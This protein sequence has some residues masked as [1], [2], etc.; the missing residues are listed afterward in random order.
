[1]RETLY[2]RQ[3]AYE[4]LRAGRRQLFRLTLVDTLRGAD[5]IDDILGLAKAAGVPVERVPRRGLDW[6]GGAR[7]QGVMLETSEYP[8]VGVDEILAEAHRRDEVPFL[9]LLDLVKDPQNLGSLLRTAEAVGVHGVVIQRRRAVGVT[10]SVVRASSGAVEHL[11][12]AQVT[13]LVNLIGILKARQVWVAGL[14][15]I[16][17]AQ[18]YDLADLTGPLA[19]VVGSEGQ[20]LR[21]LVRE[22]CDLLVALPIRGQVASLNTAVAGSVAL[23]EAWRQRQ[24]KA[25]G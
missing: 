20:G 2:G 19:F 15:R 7:H 21:R 25:T 12:V 14:G 17:G 8:Y 23:Y 24:P 11:R 1:M 10:P 22:R 16:R 3:A 13:N 9:L 6:L 5:V 4:A 18:R